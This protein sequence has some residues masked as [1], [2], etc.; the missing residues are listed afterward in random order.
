MKNHFKNIEEQHGAVV[1][2]ARQRID[3]AQRVL[4]QLAGGPPPG[5]ASSGTDDDN[6]CVI[7]LDQPKSHIFTSCFH[8]CVCGD[9]A[10]DIKAE[11]KWICPLCRRTSNDVRRVFE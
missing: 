1:L 2:Q 9:C 7:C 3:E 5:L 10:A 8:K 6:L 11:S 4:E